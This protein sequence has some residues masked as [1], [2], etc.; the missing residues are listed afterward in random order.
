[1]NLLGVTAVVSQK[2]ASRQFHNGVWRSLVAHVLWGHGAAGSNPVTP[3]LYRQIKGDLIMPVFWILV[4][5][6]AIL[7]WFILSFMYKDIGA[8]AY[9]LWKNAKDAI[10]EDEYED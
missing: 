10:E 6:T 9:R 7:L 8:S 5:L 2:Y 1:M 4:L 3:I